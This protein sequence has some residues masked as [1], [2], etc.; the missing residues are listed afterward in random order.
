MTNGAAVGGAVVAV[1]AVMTNA[2]KAMGPV[3]L[4]ESEAFLSVL[5]KM[6]APIVVH[7]P[8][9]FLTKYKYLT[10]YRGL[11]FACKSKEPLMLPASAETIAARAIALP[12][13]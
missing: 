13:L 12:D 4:V 9:G 11:Y 10:A 7:S 5:R 6:D 8:S 3:V 2:L 1:S